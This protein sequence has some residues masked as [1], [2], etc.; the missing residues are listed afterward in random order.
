MKHDKPTKP[1]EDL[2]ALGQ[3]Q[4]SHDALRACTDSMVRH[5]QD[6]QDPAELRV[7]TLTSGQPTA[8]DRAGGVS[9]S[10]G[11]L[12]PSAA[13]VWLGI[14]G[15]RPSAAGRAPSCPPK[16][17]LVLP[18]MVNDLEIGG[19]AAALAGGDQVVY[20]MRFS[21]VQAAFLGVS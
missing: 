2:G 13:T 6:L 8:T 12:N 9:R 19:D 17:L 20:V 10:I 18:I 16:G 21:T 14:G 15:A 11:V 3:L 7:V 5:L 1:H 4:R